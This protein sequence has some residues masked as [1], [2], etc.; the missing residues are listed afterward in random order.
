M[1]NYA[2]LLLK[3]RRGRVHGHLS[4]QSDVSVYN[5][6]E[7]SHIGRESAIIRGF[8]DMRLDMRDCTAFWL[9]GFS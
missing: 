9:G 6:Y 2:I 8:L 4:A 7:N 3:V 5:I 1:S